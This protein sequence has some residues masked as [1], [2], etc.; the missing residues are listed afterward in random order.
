MTDPELIPWALGQGMHEGKPL[1][2]RYRQFGW[3]FR[4]GKFG[5]RVDIEWK[6][7]EDPETGLPCGDSKSEMETFEWRMADALERPG[8][9]ILAAA[10]TSNGSKTFCYYVK[11]IE[12]LS[13]A[14]HGIP[15]EKDPYPITIFAEKDPSWKFF[16]I[17]KSSAR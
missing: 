2:I 14:I 3:F 16:R 15:Q 8:H 10:I 7:V 11:S 17:L 6:Y 12:S 4:K 13:A 9:G 1:V 5:H